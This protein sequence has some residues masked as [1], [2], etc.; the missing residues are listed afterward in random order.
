L[1]LP[2]MRLSIMVLPVL[3]LFVVLLLPVLLL[4]VQLQRLLVLVQ[5]QCPAWRTMHH[6]LLLLL[7]LA[8]TCRGRCAG[9]RS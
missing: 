5:L 7:R 8:S 1:L 3:L 2:V 6:R 9:R 4:L